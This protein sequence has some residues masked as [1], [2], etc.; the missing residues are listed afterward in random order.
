M[1]LLVNE[2]LDVTAIEAGE[3]KL[4][5]EATD[6]A[7]I[8]RESGLSRNI[9]PRKSRRESS[10]RRGT[11][12]SVPSGPE[13]DPPGRGQSAQQRSKV[14]AAWLHRHGRGRRPARLAHHRHPG[15]RSGDSGKRTRQTVQGFQPHVGATNRRGEKHGL[16]LAICRK[17]VEAHHGAI[18][19][20]NLPERGCVFRV[21]L[22]S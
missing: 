9:Q 22:P 17:I 4:A 19:A 18:T 1:L 6:L 11:A 12:S 3:L 5:L 2:L 15:S 13:Q 20:E 10:C 14:F 21:T 7:E 16:G 8:V